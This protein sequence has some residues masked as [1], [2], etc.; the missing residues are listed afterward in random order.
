MLVGIR[1]TGRSSAAGNDSVGAAEGFQGIKKSFDD[2]CAAAE[3]AAKESPIV[4]AL[5]AYHGDN[6]K[7][8]QSIND[9]GRS[10]G[11]NIVNGTGRTV[12]K[13]VDLADGFWLVTPE[14]GEARYR[15]ITEINR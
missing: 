10:V 3:G 1:S 5:R 15:Q 14:V 11:E 7:A 6:A 9:H 12:A 2:S 8:L 13:D 4:S